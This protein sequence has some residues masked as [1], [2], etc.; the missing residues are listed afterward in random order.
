M[1]LDKSRVLFMTLLSHKGWRVTVLGSVM[2][3]KTA[4]S[5][6][7]DVSHGLEVMAPSVQCFEANL[8]H[9]LPVHPLCFCM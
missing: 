2:L 5:V 7:P 4:V 6:L 1:K 3:L 9:G 8:I